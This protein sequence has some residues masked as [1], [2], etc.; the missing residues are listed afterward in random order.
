M[1]LLVA[2]DDP[3]LADVLVAGL[4]DEGYVV[5]LER[6]GETALWRATGV[7]Y[8][9][10]I[11]DIMLPGVDGLQILRRTRR[12]GRRAPVLFLT[13]RDSIADRV[14]GLD[15]GADD[16]LV[17]PFEW[18]ELTAR[19]RVL[20]RRVASCVD[21]VLRHRDLTLDP[22]RREVRRNGRV[23]ELTSKEFELL[24]L[25]I[26]QPDR[27]FSRSEIIEHL[28]DDEFDGLSNVIDVFVARLRRK[29]NVGTR[30]PLIDTVRGSGYRLGDDEHA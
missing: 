20:L 19:V 11:L 25:L 14:R 10:L 16:Y 28:Y 13:A 6:D 2:E 15:A 4:T 27:V 22:V 29:L 8:D 5:D 30:S 12:A 23:V 9:L 24:H 3:D 26:R 18:E 21:G 17:K 1:R 7:N